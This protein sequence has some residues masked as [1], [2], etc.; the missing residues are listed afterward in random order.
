MFI[1]SPNGSFGNSCSITTSFSTHCLLFS[2]PPVT[3]RITTVYVDITLTSTHNKSKV[4]NVNEYY[5][6]LK[7]GQLDSFYPPLCTTIPR[8][9]FVSVSMLMLQENQILYLFHTQ[10]L[11]QHLVTHTNIK[12]DA[13]TLN[14]IT[15]SISIPYQTYSSISLTH[16]TLRP[17]LHLLA[18]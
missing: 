15:P 16:N 14:F 3:H 1:Q 12:H 6:V 13:Q 2:I 7:L 17:Y 10:D 9:N 18:C 4:N 8:L 11:L 5:N